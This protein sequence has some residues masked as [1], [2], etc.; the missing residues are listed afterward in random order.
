MRPGGPQEGVGNGARRWMVATGA[1]A[2]VQN[3][4]YRPARP[5]P[6]PGVPTAG[7]GASFRRATGVHGR[8]TAMTLDVADTELKARHRAMWGK[9]DYPL[10]AEMFLLPVGERLVEA[11]G[12]PRSPPSSTPDDAA[13]RPAAASRGVAAPAVGRGKPPDL[14]VRRSRRLHRAG[15]GEPLHHR[16]RAGPRPR[17]A[18]RGLLRTHDRGARAGCHERSGRGVRRGARWLLRPVG[19]GWGRRCPLREGVPGRGGQEAVT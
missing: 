17:G 14:A 4:A 12:S 11:A 3:P 10:M 16:L 8:G 2:P 5:P 9:G 19:P 18:L 15:S 7:A 6:A 1:R 13:V